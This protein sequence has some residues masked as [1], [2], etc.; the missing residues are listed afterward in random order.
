M[1]IL[2]DT[3]SGFPCP[4]HATTR[5]E[6][7]KITECVDGVYYPIIMFSWKLNGSTCKRLAND[8]C[9]YRIKEYTPSSGWQDSKNTPLTPVD[10]NN[11]LTA[12]VGP[13]YPVAHVN[14]TK[15]SHAQWVSPHPIIAVCIATLSLYNYL[16]EAY[17]FCRD[18]DSTNQ[19]TWD[20]RCDDMHTT[21][22]DMSHFDINACDAIETIVGDWRKQL[23][24]C[25]RILVSDEI[26]KMWYTIFRSMCWF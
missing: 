25:G 9:V 19:A 8:A 20:Q 17:W 12:L 23:T 3:N 2:R 1:G 18:D 21:L 15:W 26:R 6:S 5:I 11:G 24:D 4:T 14:G 16:A 10:F 7:K 13:V 22:V